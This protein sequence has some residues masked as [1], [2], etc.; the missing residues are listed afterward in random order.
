MVSS[1]LPRRISQCDVL[2]VSMSIILTLQR[3]I[4]LMN[5]TM[6]TISG[7]DILRPSCIKFRYFTNNVHHTNTINGVVTVV[8]LVQ[9]MLSFGKGS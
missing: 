5:N 6:L 2:D 9:A 7:H 3:L 4:I 8:T 1:S